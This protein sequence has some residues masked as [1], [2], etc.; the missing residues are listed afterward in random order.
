[1]VSLSIVKEETVSTVSRRE[2]VMVHSYTRPHIHLI[3]STKDRTKL[4]HGEARDQ[5][6]YYI[7][8]YARENG[9][10]L[11]FIAVQS[12][13]VHL[14]VELL[15]NQQLDVM[16]KLIKGES[17]HWINS[18]NII[19]PRFSWQRGYGAFSVSQSHVHRVK[20]YIEQQDDHHRHRTFTEEYR[21]FLDRHGFQGISRTETDE[22]VSS[23]T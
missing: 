2:A 22:S 15:S 5:V 1:M 6:R 20:Q 13:H 16:V 14:L 3:W 8:E 18:M 10:L 11:Q 21:L 19:R 9:I 23:D 17:S 12:D 4:L 7:E